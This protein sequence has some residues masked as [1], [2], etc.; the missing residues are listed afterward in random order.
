V[1]LA[2]RRHRLAAREE[3]SLQELMGETFIGFHPAVDP[4]WA[5]FWSLDDHRGSPPVR[6]TGDRATNP[7]EVIAAL[8]VRVAITAVP[9]SVAPVIASVLADVVAIPVIGARPCE[10]ALVGHADGRNP[11]VRS[12]MSYAEA[13]TERAEPLTA[14][15]VSD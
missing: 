4:A 11:L 9:A 6:V 2:S 8:A 1:I 5:G 12:L 14:E 3:L 13:T 7:Q 15:P 10:I